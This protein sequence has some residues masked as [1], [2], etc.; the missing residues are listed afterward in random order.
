MLFAIIPARGG[1][2]R[3]KNKNI[4]SFN[5]KPIIF[6]VI[7]KL[8]ELNLFKEIIVSTDSKKIALLAK[9]YGA[10]VPFVRSKKL[11]NDHVATR[12]VVVDAI[13]KIDKNKNDI[14]CC[15]YPTSVF[16]KKSQILKALKLLKKN[17]NSFVFGA[18]K[19]SHPIQ[20]SF[21]RRK[22]IIFLKKKY[23]NFR[24]QDLTEYFHD[25]GQFY[26][27]NENTWRT[28]KIINENS[29]FVEIPLNESH[30]IDNK[31]D[32]L[33]AEQ[34]WKFLKKKNKL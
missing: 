23:M 3:I 25:A 27:A 15:I 10:K 20:R 12:D 24:T 31:S 13:N 26:F 29:L 33:L 14:F 32:W 8:K 34:L 6:H 18:K 2:K 11:S 7:K 16:L 30:D 21:F 4:K 9:K 17:K 1:S 28:K 19:Y 5:G 22:K